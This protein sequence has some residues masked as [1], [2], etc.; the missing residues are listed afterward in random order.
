M[1]VYPITEQSTGKDT[2][3]DPGTC[4]ESLGYA[5]VKPIRKASGIMIATSQNKN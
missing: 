4:L 1:R 2:K 5:Y 3:L